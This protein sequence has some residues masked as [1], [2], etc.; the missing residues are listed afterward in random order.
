MRRREEAPLFPCA[1]KAELT[2]LADG[3]NGG[4]ERQKSPICQGFSLGPW[5][6]LIERTVWE[7]HAFPG[8][9]PR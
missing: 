8:A 1:V 6:A 5:V 2:G 7:E 4:Y 3:L 9:N